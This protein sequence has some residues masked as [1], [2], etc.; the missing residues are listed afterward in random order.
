M[1]ADVNLAKMADLYEN[2]LI[3]PQ[4]LKE[5]V[6]NAIQ[7]LS[8]FAER[9][10]KSQSRKEIINILSRYLFSH[11]WSLIIVFIVNHVDIY[12]EFIRILRVFTRAG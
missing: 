2:Q 4:N 7:D 6:D 12:Q 1:F 11:S 10:N 9:S 3:N 8:N 5:A